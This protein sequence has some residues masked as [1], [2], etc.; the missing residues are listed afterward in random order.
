MGVCA[1]IVVLCVL[2]FIIYIITLLLVDC[3]LRLAWAT[4]VGKSIGEPLCVF[5]GCKHA[6]LNTNNEIQDNAKES[7]YIHNK[8]HIALNVHTIRKL[9]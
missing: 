5:A 7:Y 3:D 2:G 6:P 8:T 1:W 4:K 9:F